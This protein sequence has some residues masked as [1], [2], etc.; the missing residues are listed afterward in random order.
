MPLSGTGSDP[1]DL[2]A[3]LT[4]SR[5]DACH[6]RAVGK[7]LT[8]VR[9]VLTAPVRIRIGWR[10]NAQ[11]PLHGS[12]GH[13]FSV[14]RVTKSSTMFM[15]ISLCECRDQG[16][17]LG[18][19]CD[20]C[21]D[22]NLFASGSH[23]LRSQVNE[24]GSQFWLCFKHCLNRAKSAVIDQGRNRAPSRSARL[25]H[26]SPPIRC[27]RRK[28]EDRLVT[29]RIHSKVAAGSCCFSFGVG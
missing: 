20:C 27:C 15:A 19:V 6:L 1:G 26:T 8:S 14:E 7:G 13:V 11:P 10:S 21:F 9:A 24:D 18:W 16:D 17:G 12:A 3:V 29:G 28:F 2:V 25:G 4:D 5:R 22:N 23:Q